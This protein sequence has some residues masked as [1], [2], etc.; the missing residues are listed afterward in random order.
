[1]HIRF[2]AVRGS[3]QLADSAIQ[4]LPDKIPKNT[5]K[6]FTLNHEFSNEWNK[7]L[8]PGANGQQLEFVIKKEHLPYYTQQ[9]V[10]I[11]GISIIIESLKQFDNNYTVNIILPNGKLD[12][13]NVAVD[14]TNKI[15]HT[16]KIGP[17]AINS[18]VLGVWNI[19]IESDQGQIQKDNIRNIF[20]LVQF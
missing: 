7:F 12:N 20:L 14:E 10:K 4:C 2:T 9:D 17:G 3:K 16:L 13:Q 15:V 1:L 18:P 19:K 11:S 5:W 8:N 6:L